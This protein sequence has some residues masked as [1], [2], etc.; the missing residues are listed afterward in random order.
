[1]TLITQCP[2][3]QTR[4]KIVTDQL[5]KAH[6][7]VRCGQCQTVFNA[8]EYL[9]AQASTPRRDREAQATAATTPPVPEQPSEAP[10]PAPAPK[11]QPTV[12]TR[13]T[14]TA[15]EQTSPFPPLYPIQQEEPVREAPPRTEP[16]IAEAEPEPLPYAPPPRPGPR[17]NRTQPAQAT[18]E[19]PPSQPA[20]QPAAAARRRLVVEQDPTE[21]HAHVEHYDPDNY[22]EE[23]FA[24][25]DYYRQEP[26]A[27]IGPGLNK[28]FAVL[29]GLGI[30]FLIMQLLVINRVNLS[31]NFPDLAPAIGSVSKLFGRSV[32]LPSNIDMLRTEWTE[33][34]RV[35][36]HP[37][38]LQID[39]VLKNHA[40]Y[41]QDYPLL[42]LSLKNKQGQVVARR[43][44][45]PKEYLKPTDMELGR[46]N[47]NSEVR[48]SL[49]M[50]TGELDAQG[51]ALRW[52]YPPISKS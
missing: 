34:S 16:V 24:L 12:I 51:Y 2:H 18:P 47:P 7:R 45:T 21:L 41:A 48:I 6:G 25:D 32:P 39:A 11:P 42:E 49:R 33:P 20:P 3:C 35:P 27:P 17:P 19:P 9:D 26:K 52:H 30:G 5:A 14:L 23:D 50:D 37:S 44:L 1:M 40:N 29:G 4:F 8:L 22:N 46:F 36:E 31:A 15:P 43:Q 28:L 10:A 38:L 13:T